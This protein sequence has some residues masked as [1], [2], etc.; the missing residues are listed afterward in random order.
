MPLALEVQ[1]FDVAG[2]LALAQICGDGERGGDGVDA[3]PVPD[4]G[5]DAL[6][7]VDL[8][9]RADVA[10]A[11]GDVLPTPTHE[12]LFRGRLPLQRG[13]VLAF[14]RGV[15][16]EGDLAG[17]RA[18]GGRGEGS[19]ELLESGGIVE[20]VVLGKTS[21]KE[22]LDQGPDHLL[23]GGQWLQ[24]GV[25]GV[26]GVDPNFDHF[27]I[28]PP[29]QLQTRLERAKPHLEILEGGNEIFQLAPEQFLGGGGEGDVG[30]ETV[31]HS[32]EEEAQ[33]GGE[34]VVQTGIVSGGV[35][36][37]AGAEGE[38]VDFPRRVDV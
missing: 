10:V 11:E 3:V 5:A 7:G 21:S 37:E 1:I 19:L 22:Q 9:L 31:G 33:S 2:A 23:F 13:V 6:E 29:D 30:G 24:D 18:L 17:G 20:I 38:A 12:L 36:V 28:S 4:G 15:V 34:V 25:A 16:L 14:E 27:Q 8:M 26:V 32:L 35:A